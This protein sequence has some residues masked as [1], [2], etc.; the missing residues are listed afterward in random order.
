MREISAGGVVYRN[1]DGTILLLMI[2]DRFGAITLA[3]G[4]QEAG[5]TLE[6]T[7]IREIEEETAVKGEIKQLLEVIHY[8]YKHPSTGETVEKEV[9]YYLVQ[10]LSDQLAAQVEEINHVQWM[11]AGE[12]WDMHE[13]A[14][15]DNNRSVLA[16]ALNAL[17]IQPA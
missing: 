10:A 4:K 8:T 15:Y 6:E 13:K 9:H 11:T 14:G 7:A 5:E 2:Q 17:G 16:K 1:Q 3:K 12:A